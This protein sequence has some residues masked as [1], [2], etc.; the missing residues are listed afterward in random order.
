MGLTAYASQ[1]SKPNQ[2]SNQN[3]GINGQG[4]SVSK[5]YLG[6][7]YRCFSFLERA[8]RAILVALRVIFSTVF[9]CVSKP[10]KKFF[11]IKNQ[12]SP[13]PH[14][15]VKKEPIREKTQ[16]TPLPTSFLQK[17]ENVVNHSENLH[18]S[19]LTIHEQIPFISS[20]LSSPESHQNLTTEIEPKQI[21]HT[22]ATITAQTIESV[23]QQVIPSPLEAEQSLPMHAFPREISLENSEKKV[24]QQKKSNLNSLEKFKEDLLQI[25]CVKDS[26]KMAV[27]LS[28]ITPTNLSPQDVVN[29]IFEVCHEKSIPI[30]LDALLLNHP[31]LTLSS[32][33]KIRKT[34][35]EDEQHFLNNSSLFE[36]F[37]HYGLDHNEEKMAACYDLAFRINHPYIYPLAQKPV[38]ASDYSLNFL[39]VNEYPQ[40]RNQ[41]NAQNIFSDGSDVS[42]NAECIK[43]PQELRKLE[44]GEQSLENWDQIKKSFMY[45]ISKWADA[46]SHSDTQINLW[47]DSALV[48]QKAQQK[49]FEMIA[50]IS[51]S[52]SVPIKLRDIRQL[53]TLK[54]E[55]EH[56][57]HPGAPLYYRVDLAKAL[58]ADHVMRKSDI[59]TEGMTLEMKEDAKPKY[60]IISDKDVEPMTRE[61]IFD[62]RTLDFLSSHGYVFNRVSLVSNFENSFSIFNKEKAGLQSLHYETIIEKTAAH[63]TEMRKYPNTNH[64]LN[65]QFIFRQYDHFF[66]Q[67]YIRYHKDIQQKNN[68]AARKVVKCPASQFNFGNNSPYQLETCRFIGDDNIPYTKNRLSQS[69]SDEKQI[70]SLIHWQAKPL[71][72]PV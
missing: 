41:D 64:T 19:S 2:L 68:I 33:D 61:Q 71:K 3:K 18:S 11:P 17:E 62:Q 56:S 70:E 69:H 28:A 27:K 26:Y 47:Y 31:S 37:K 14:S 20:I 52:R 50:A 51:Q 44:K 58:I 53:P 30:L 59:A 35:I 22:V 1:Q 48:T 4:K 65:S 40:N 39:W 46:H 21:P 25:Y 67:F 8:G 55:I 49:T 9:D 10:F 6:R 60:G 66:A 36:M 42:E 12:K 57:F 34:I 32:Y 38:L 13:L 29:T 5:L 7:T 24:P 45:R 16:Q 15:I 72:T 43:D 23:R 54:G 63:I